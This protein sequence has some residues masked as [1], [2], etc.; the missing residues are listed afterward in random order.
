[1]SCYAAEL[2]PDFRSFF[3]IKNLFMKGRISYF[4]GKYLVIWFLIPFI[5]GVIWIAMDWIFLRPTPEMTEYIREV[6][7]FHYNT[8]VSDITYCGGLFFLENEYGAPYLDYKMLA[9]YIGFGVIMFSTFWIVVIFGVKS[10]KLVAELPKQGESE[11]TYKLQ[12]QLF[13][14]LVAQ[15]FIPITFLFI[16]IGLLFTAPL[17][18]FD[19]EP[20]SFLVTIFYSMYPA[21]DPLPIMLIVADYRQALS[22]LFRTVTGTRSNHIASSYTDQQVTSIS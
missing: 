12:S 3:M 4:R 18:R 9:G 6:V 11:Y 7:L 2:I 10:Y 22:E 17:L 14:A 8:N 13:K 5:S 20:A 21:L 1:M 15:A 19:I 16:P